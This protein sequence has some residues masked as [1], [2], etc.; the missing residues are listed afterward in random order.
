MIPSN[1]QFQMRLQSPFL[2]EDILT[3]YNCVK[4]VDS[5][6]RRY[7]LDIAWSSYGLKGL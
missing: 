5:V 7:P 2:S 4:L 1:L 6:T 3:L